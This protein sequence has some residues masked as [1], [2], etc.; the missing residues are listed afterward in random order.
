MIDSYHESCPE[1]TPPRHAE[2][3]QPW[4]GKE[5]DRK[6]K[7]VR[8]ALNRAMNTSMDED[9]LLYKKAKSEYKKCIR[10][11]RSIGWRKFCGNIETCKQANRIRNILA[12]QNTSGSMSLKK[13]DGS[14]STSPDE[15]Q[16][17]LIETHFPGCCVTQEANRHDDI[18]T[19]T[20]EDWNLAQRVVTMDKIHWAI[21]SFLPYKAAGP[22]GIFPALLQWGGKALIVRLAAIMRA[23]LALKYV[24][25][26][27]REVKVTFIPKPGKSDYT[28]PKSYRP[29]SLTSFLLKTMERMCERELRGSAL[30]NLPLHDKQHAYSLGKSTESALHKVITKIEEAIQNKEICLGSF[31]DI[32]G[33]FDRTNFSSIKGALG[34]HKVEPALID[35]IVYMLSTRI[36]KIAG[37]SQPIQI[38]KGCPQ[39]GVLSPLLWN[40]VINEL[41]SKLNDNHFYTVGYADDLTILVSG[42]T[43]SIVC[44]LTQA[45]LRIVERW[46]REHDLTVNPNKTVLVMFTQKRKLNNYHPPSLFST[47][48]QL[49]SEV[50]Y[51]G[52]TLDSKLNWNKHIENK[53]NKASI[54][55]WQC[56]NM[57]G[58]RWG[59]T[60]KIIL[61][62]YKTVIRPMI[63]YGALVWWTK[64]NEATIIKK[65]QRYQRL[66]CMAA[67]GCMRTTPTAALEAMLELTPLH[68]HI[69]QEA[70]LAAIRLKTL[71]LWSKNSVPHTGIIDRIHSKIPILQAKYDRIPKQFVFDKK[72]KIQLNENSQPEGLSPKELKIFTDGSKTNEGVGCGAFSEDL[73][74]HICTPLGTYNTVFQAECMGII[75]AAIAIDARK[76]ND[77]PIRILTD[78]RAVLQA[79]RC[80]VVNSGLIYECHQR[81]NEVCKNNNVTLQWIKGHSGSRGNDAADELARRGSA[82]A[83]IGPEPIIPIPFG[84]VCSL[85]RRH[86]TNQHAQ[87]WKNLVDCRQARDAL[88]EINSRLTK[89]LMRLN[90]PQIRIVTSAI[91]GHGTFNKHLFTIGVTDSPLCRAC[92]GEEE[93]AAHVLLKCPEVATYRAKHLGTPGSLPEVACNIKGLLSF[94]GEIS[95]LE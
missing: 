58:K 44:D 59:L 86:F 83:T 70:T 17:I 5:L 56:R 61:W 1:I 92:M 49:S 6:R 87:L 29:I 82:L 41:I 66:A 50:K 10:Y 13:P 47:K 34:R 8:K 85:V 21:H 40:M 33:A 65:L 39:G 15:A 74:I 35:W 95:W 80:N 20:A 52:L 63:T 45:A 32:E 7:K 23:C 37:E 64:T 94:F 9:W 22:D 78:S 84:N 55:F 68:L 71:N 62:L 12:K 76:V 2:V 93:T 38:K 48:L 42:K 19:S 36:I 88:P 18:L 89:V 51:L 16:R 46:C 25:R 27:W 91:T 60:P 26:G 81:L 77:F 4:W 43:A 72:Y 24:P 11:R 54:T 69:Q 28:D 90:K 30:M 67:T 14:Y 73:N 79:L 3:K 75:Q 53:I 31:I 57:I